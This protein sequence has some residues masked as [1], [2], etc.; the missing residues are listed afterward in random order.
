MATEHTSRLES[1]PG[2]LLQAQG[3]SGPHPDL[4]GIRHQALQ[5]INLNGVLHEEEATWESTNSP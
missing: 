3:H 5:H 2:V 1:V 4:H